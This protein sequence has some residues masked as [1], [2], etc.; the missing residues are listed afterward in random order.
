MPHLNG[1]AQEPTQQFEN[2]KADHIRLSLD[3]RNQTAAVSG[4]DQVELVHE[5]LPEL[6]FDEVSLNTKSL[7]LDLPTPFLVSSMTAGHVGSLD[8]NRRLALACAER[9]WLMGVGSQR[10][11]LYDPDASNEWR[12]LRKENPK[13][14]LL[15]NLGL[16]QLIQSKTE[17]VQRL[18]DA[19]EATAMIIHTNPLQECLQ[20][21]GTPYFKGGL[22]A[23]E[24]T[25]KALEVP[26][27]L[28]ETGCGFSQSTLERL[29][30]TGL[31]AVDVSGAGGT[32][33]GRIEGSRNSQDQIRH[34]SS[35]SFADW[36]ISTLESLKNAR[37]VQLPF[38][39]WAS[40]G[41]RTGVQA[42]IVMALGARCVGF[43][44]PILRAA[45]EGEAELRR[46]MQTIE[47]ELKTA[48]FCT[49]S[50]NPEDL[51]KKDVLRWKN[52]RS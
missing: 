40:G 6:D 11:E 5:A 27:V 26:L 16:S 38:E 34:Q 37:R 43:A 22:K 21:E 14:R 29:K 2:R 42:A 1:E 25:A 33:W 7:D 19:L 17:D 51:Q 23:L 44:T 31:A 12:D 39:V 3:E 49:G 20:V 18:V 36:G 50:R 45:L 15:G 52:H 46:Q 24:K 13:V 4:F 35:R 30:E 41:V 9:G 10:R 32:H 28:K 8:L 48:L 47:Y